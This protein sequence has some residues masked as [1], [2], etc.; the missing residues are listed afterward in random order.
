MTRKRSSSDLANSQDAKEA[1]FV[2]EIR[3]RYA[4]TDQMG[5]AYY[6]NYLVWFEVGRVEYCR[7]RGLR[8]RDFER[9]FGSYLAVAESYCR[10]HAPASY[11]DL[12][13]IQTRLESLRR[14]MMTFQYEIRKQE[15]GLL[16]AEGRTVHV[17]LDKSG[18][19][20]SFPPEFSLRFQPLQ[21]SQ[22]GW[23]ESAAT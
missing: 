17:L 1:W 11:D 8:Y 10:Y 9:S 23:P 22:P 20:K 12:L 2:T 15:D 18:R 16:I 19:P 6:A 5:V 21:S 3:V 4:E 7:H 14:R 13:L